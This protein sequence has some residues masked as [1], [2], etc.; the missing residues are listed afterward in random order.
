MSAATPFHPIVVDPKGLAA[1][2][3]WR[4]AKL[5][6]VA[7]LESGHTPSRLR[8]DWWGGDISWLSLTEIRA[9]DGQW[10][11][12]TKLRTNAA[13]I[14]NSAARILPIGTVCLSR[15]ASVGFVAIMGRPMATSQD[16]ANWVC[17]PELDPDFLMYALIHAR[18]SLRDLAT[19]ATHKTIY[20]PTLKAFHVCMPEIHEQKRVA[21]LAREGLKEVEIARNA[22]EK[23]LREIDG[24]SHKLLETAFGGR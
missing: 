15:T 13:G 2:A 19:G 5:T 7:D 24:L 11:E 20:M 3:G 12:Q 18:A 8:P 23:Q 21:K 4:W 22:A 10:V 1:P 14:A 6:E 17:K 9:L 16:F